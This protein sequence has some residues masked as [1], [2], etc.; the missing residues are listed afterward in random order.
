MILDRQLIEGIIHRN[1]VTV[2]QAKLIY[3]EAERIIRIGRLRIRLIRSKDIGEP[4][5][6]GKGVDIVPDSRI[7]NAS[8]FA[9]HSKRGELADDER[10]AQTVFGVAPRHP[11]CIDDLVR[12][13]VNVDCKDKVLF[14]VGVGSSG[15]SQRFVEMRNIPIPRFLDHADVMR[16]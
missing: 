16:I 11:Q 6:R 14:G 9:R 2:H 7:V 10:D 12:V 13:A 8:I 1:P 4:P 5:V 15:L 3:Q